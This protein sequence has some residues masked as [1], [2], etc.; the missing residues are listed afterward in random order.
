MTSDVPQ[1]LSRALEDYLETIYELVRD[2]QYARVKDIARAR[3]VKAGSVTPA[4]HRLAE[5]GLIRYVQ[6]EYI[7]LTEEGERVARRVFARHQML[8]RFFMEFLRMPEGGARRDACA[9]EHSLSDE[10]MDGLVRLFEFLRVCPEVSGAFLERFHGCPV[11]QAGGVDDC[12]RACES[13]RKSLS[14]PPMR[15]V[16]ELKP[17]Q[18]GR[19]TQVNAQGGLRQRLLDMGFL[20]DVQIEVERVAPAGGPVWVKLQGFQL[21]LRQKEAQAVLVTPIL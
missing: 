20:P 16:A 12:G 7:G 11:I 14:V 15:S 18:S 6:R 17:G 13:A 2:N 19:V 4:M 3:D 21:S 9:M 1:S 10:A 5:L 8:T